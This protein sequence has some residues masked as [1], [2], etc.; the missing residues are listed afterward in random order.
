VNA[1][2][3]VSETAVLAA[4]V[5]RVWAVVDDT[6]R[7]AEWVVSVLEVTDHHGRAVVGRTYSERNR[8]VG[9]LT[10]RST[11]TVREIEPLRLRVDTGMGFAPMHDMTNTFVLRPVM[12]NGEPGTELTYRVTYRPGLGAVGRLVDRLQQ[13]GL[14]AA[15]Q[16]SMRRLERIA[17]SE[18]ELPE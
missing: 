15:F 5:E 18:A 1:V 10:T 9:P 2:S 8:T 3:E 4:P 6:S 16:A 13:P 17:I 7:Y 12:V 11:W 14:R